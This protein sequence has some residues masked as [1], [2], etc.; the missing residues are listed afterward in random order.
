MSRARWVIGAVGR[1][2]GSAAGAFRTASADAAPYGGLAAVA[3]ALR[4]GAPPALAWQRGWGVRCDDG[5]PRW[6]ELVARCGG[7]RSVAAAVRAAARLSGATGAPPA[8]VLDRLGGVLADEAEIAGQRRAAMA[9]PRATARLL[10]WL[11]A[12]GVV[13]GAAVGAD[14]VGVLLDGRGGTLLLLG[15]VLLTW[16]GRRW[17]Q[18]LLAAAARAAGGG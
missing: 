13:L 2:A 6:D 16:S 15:S 1:P 9:G 3:A 8:A 11:P 5:V 17:S 10:T 4:A 14:P 18:R 12:F 7:D